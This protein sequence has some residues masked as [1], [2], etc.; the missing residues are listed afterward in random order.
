MQHTM[1]ACGRG[2]PGPFRRHRAASRSGETPS[3]RPRNALA[4]GLA[5]GRRLTLNAK[6]A[7]TVA[8]AFS[9]LMA[10][11]VAV[12][13]PLQQ[14]Q[15]ERVRQRDERLVATLRE[16]YERDLV[17]DIL[18]QNR[19]SLALDAAAFCRQP[20]LLWITVQAKGMTLSGTADADSKRRLLEG[21]P[22]VD[23]AD[24]AALMI[25]ERGAAGLV[26]ADGRASALPDIPPERLA[27]WSVGTVHEP[28]GRFHE[29]RWP[30]GVAALHSDTPLMAADQVFGRLHVVYSLAE[31]ERAERRPTTALP[32]RWPP[33]A[34]SSASRGSTRS[35]AG[36]PS[37]RTRRSAS[38]RRISRKAWPSSTAGSKSRTGQ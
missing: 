5:P 18:S 24:G 17:Y 10:C 2:S 38:P 27:P 8:G 29:I 16:K 14:H 13:L 30:T 7:L 6:V 23:P 1:S 35:C 34:G 9:V 19:E 36:T 11:F 28:S 15:R 33:W 4:P 26:A 22:E 3:P 31:V 32:R 37:S 20:G 21:V 12:L 25:G